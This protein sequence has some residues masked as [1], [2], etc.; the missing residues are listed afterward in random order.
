MLCNDGRRPMRL[1]RLSCHEANLQRSFCLCGRG[2]SSGI[3]GDL[4]ARLIGDREVLRR[5][6]S[7]GRDGAGLF[8]GGTRRSIQISEQRMVEP[9]L[10]AAQVEQLPD[11]RGYLKTA[12]SPVWHAVRI[13]C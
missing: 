5:Q 12:S 10:L 3:V 7:C 8:A 2:Y 6:R 13:G 11:L 1:G 4:A 9:A